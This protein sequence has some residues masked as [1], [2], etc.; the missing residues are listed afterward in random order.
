MEGARANVVRK[1][2][3]KFNFDYIIDAFATSDK[4][5]VLPNPSLFL[6]IKSI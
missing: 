1:P 2:D 3:G 4:E 5:K 6:L